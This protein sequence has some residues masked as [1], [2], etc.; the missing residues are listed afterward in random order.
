MGKRIYVDGGILIKSMDFKYK[1]ATCL[2]DIPEG[3]EVLETNCSENGSRYLVIDEKH[4]QSI[5]NEYCAKTFFTSLY[6]CSYYLNSSYKKAYDNYVEKREELKDILSNLNTFNGNRKPTLYKLLLLNVITLF[7]A[8]VCETIISKVTSSEECF[9][10]YYN[11]LSPT[12]IESLINKS[13][14]EKEKRVIKYIMKQSY[15]QKD[16]VDNVFMKVYGIKNISSYSGIQKWFAWRHRIVHRNGREK[17][18]SFHLFTEN[19]VR[20]AIETVDKLVLKIMKLITE[21]KEE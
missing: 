14:G 6:S 5:F 18:G 19:D 12:L 20:N 8:Y 4:P 16:D 9:N 17:N 15:A 2:C 10:N 3:A 13:Q 1:G 7:D 21:E 11:Q